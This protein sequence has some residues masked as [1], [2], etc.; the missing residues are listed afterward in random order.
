MECKKSIFLSRLRLELQGMVQG[1]GLRPYV[2]RTAKQLNLTG[3][4][5]NHVHGVTI[6]VQGELSDHFT[7]SLLSNLPPLA[8]IDSIH[9]VLLPF[10]FG[11]TQFLILESAVGKGFAT[12]ISPDICICDDCL[13]ELFDPKSR[14]YH[15]PFLNCTNCGPRFTIIDGV[16]YDRNQTTM[17]VFPLCAHC[18][19]DYMNPNNRRYHA[20]PTA[21]C[22]CGPKLS[23]S[24]SDMVS[25]IKSGCILAIKGQGGYQLICDARNEQAVATLRERKY[26]E[27]KPFAIMVVNVQSAKKWVD[28]GVVA[29]ALLRSRER[30]IVL[31]QKKG[32]PLA[33]SVAKG[34]SHLGVM[35]PYTPFHYLL[36]N[37][38]VG[39]SD[40]L[41]WL[42][43]AYE[44]VLIVTSANLSDQPLI[45]DDEE[46]ESELKNV[47]DHI[48]SYN[49]KIL[50]RAD[51]SVMQ[52][53][54]GAPSFIRRARGYVPECIQLEH[55]GPNILALGGHL[56]NTFCITRSNEA[57][58]SQHIGN[59][60]NSRAIRFFRESLNHLL[61][62]LDVKP[63]YIAHDQHPD[64]YTTRFAQAY[65]IPAVAVQHHHAHLASVAAEHHIAEP[66]LGLA[67]DGYGYGENGEAWGGEL[68]LLDEK[69]GYQRLG[70]LRPIPQVGGDRASKEPWRIAAGVLHMLAFDDEIEKRFYSE[71]HSGLLAVLL[72][73]GAYASTSSCGRLFDAAAALLGVRNRSQYEGQAA[74]ELES[75]VTQAQVL[76]NGWY[77]KNES[78]LDLLPLMDRLRCLSPVEGANIFHGTLVTALSDWLMHWSHTTGIKTVLL[79]GGCFLN[80]I[81]TEKLI[82]N[83]QIGGIVPLLPKQL[84][85]NDG[86]L[87]LG[88]ALVAAKNRC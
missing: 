5:F 13:Q 83:C 14:Y 55:S 78:V 54:K 57:F 56:K 21:C 26:R 73:K 3:F 59:L 72:R 86:G 79:S 29:E 20:Q 64:F 47:A 84:P 51:D 23:M 39:F 85:P 25:H 49:R 38:L 2:Y 76:K 74:M 24:I 15:Y 31:L 35:L 17:R 44:E 41:G 68:L 52:V 40:G 34:L 88:Q 7:D 81:L 28:C 67:L 32:Q 27:A 18:Q 12:R 30:P 4:V 10:Q 61:K 43:D 60:D 1:V 75:L 66:V 58:I 11:E 50:M 45:T 87:C 63:E 42:N 65:G 71:K 80:R 48:V 37:G 8:K 16:P 19:A 46:A 69:G 62:I 70:C 77:F 22:E 82:E 33:A 36:F 6:E 53:I 9:T